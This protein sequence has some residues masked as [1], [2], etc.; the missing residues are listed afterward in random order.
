MPKQLAMNV[1]SKG[2]SS[3][4]HFMR[5]QQNSNQNNHIILQTTQIIVTKMLCHSSQ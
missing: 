1:F 3:A 5:K 4:E 2:F